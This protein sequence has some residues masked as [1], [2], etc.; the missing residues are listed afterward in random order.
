[1]NQ[2]HATLVHTLQSIHLLHAHAV[3]KMVSCAYDHSCWID[4]VHNGSME[5]MMRQVMRAECSPCKTPL[6]PAHM[7]SN[8]RSGRLRK[9]C[10]VIR[11]RVAATAQRHLAKASF[12]ISLLD[13]GSLLRTPTRPRRSVDEVSMKWACRRTGV[14]AVHA[15]AYGWR[16]TRSALARTCS[17]GACVS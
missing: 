5:R 9:D 7:L 11:A 15:W 6:V 10:R 14:C 13:L 4:R 3:S 12:H 2:L 1:M 17:S 16:W 8:R